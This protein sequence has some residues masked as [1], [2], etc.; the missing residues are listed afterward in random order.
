MAPQ[1]LVS[2]SDVLIST[3]MNNKLAVTSH[4]LDLLLYSVHLS[5]IVYAGTAWFAADETLPLVLKV[6]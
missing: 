5:N 4:K 2:V 1:F 6:V 3:I